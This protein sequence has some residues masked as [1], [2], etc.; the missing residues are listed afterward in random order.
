[1]SRFRRESTT[2]FIRRV[3]GVGSQRSIVFLEDD[4]D[5]LLRL[6]V[7]LELEDTGSGETAGSSYP[8]DRRGTSSVVVSRDFGRAMS[9]A[10]L[11]E[12]RVS[13]FAR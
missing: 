3:A 6:E 4:F 8:P 5:F 10:Y 7:T 9:R 11:I 1:M 12:A 2:A 13:Y